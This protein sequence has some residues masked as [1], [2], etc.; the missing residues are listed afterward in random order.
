VQRRVLPYETNLF[1][2]GTGLA[3]ALAGL[4]DVWTQVRTALRPA[5]HSA[6]DVLRAREAAA[7]TAHA[8]WMYSAALARTESRGMH[9]RTDHPDLD[10]AQHHRLRVHGLDRITLTPSPVGDREPTTAV[11]R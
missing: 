7:M 6:R 11:V 8:R 1:R 9:R 4:D 5:S 10:P 3:A 2:T